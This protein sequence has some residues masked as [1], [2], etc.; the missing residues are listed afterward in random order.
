MIECIFTIDYEIYGNGEGSLRELV[1][2]P[3]R[4]LKRLF[5]KVAAKFVVFVESVELQR[6]DAYR[7]DSAITEIRKQIREFY[8]EGFEIALHLH[9]Q[10]CNAIYHN[11]RWLL[12]ASE[13]NLCPLARERIEEIVED[14]IT[15]LQNVLDVPDFNPLSFR[16]GNWLFQPTATAASVLAR[17]NIKIDSSVFKGG[18]Q[19]KHKLDY[20]RALRNGYF[21]RFDNDAATAEPT[22]SLLE[23]P[24]YTAMVPFWKM[25]TGKRLRLQQKVTAGTGALRRRFDRL[26][27]LLRFRQPLKFDFCRMSLDE[28]RSMLDR[29]I[30]DDRYSPQLLKPMVAIGHTKD[31]ADLKTVEA[32]LSYVNEKQIPISTF[33]DVY[34]KCAQHSTDDGVGSDPHLSEIASTP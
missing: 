11:G 13:Y 30:E 9:P 16:A 29:V 7:T 20:R 5:D 15:Y 19:Y 26:P 27:D 3:A 25:V 6:I 10:W 2:E 24:I 12:D 17:H 32:F 23:I 22:G 18:L 8:D 31:L 21:W 34:S 28:L 14:A 33:R 4:E 1:Y